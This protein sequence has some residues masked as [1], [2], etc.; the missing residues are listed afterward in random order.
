M[1]G[2]SDDTPDLNSYAQMA[3]RRKV[4]ERE[5]L[6][7]EEYV[8]EG[9]S[10]VYHSAADENDAAHQPGRQGAKPFLKKGGGR[11]EAPPEAPLICLLQAHRQ[12]ANS[13]RQQY[14]CRAPEAQTGA[15]W[16]SVVRRRECECLC[17]RSTDLSSSQ[18]LLRLSRVKPSSLNHRCPCAACV[19][20]VRER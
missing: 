7:G 9:G 11:C 12:I 13:T 15:C 17:D 14:P 6:P 16:I 19:P 1:G 18:N 3:E 10:Q 5:Q 20:G 8:Y 2:P 4:S